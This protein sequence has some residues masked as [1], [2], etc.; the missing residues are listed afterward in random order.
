MIQSFLNSTGP[1]NSMPVKSLQG[2]IFSQRSLLVYTDIAK[3]SS[4]RFFCSSHLPLYLP[5]YP[6]HPSKCCY[7]I[8]SSSDV[9]A[10]SLQLLSGC[11]DWSGPCPARLGC[12]LVLLEWALSTISKTNVNRNRGHLFINHVLTMLFYSAFSTLLRC[13]LLFYFTEISVA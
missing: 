13:R 10:L 2:P 4:K 3:P 7:V 8:P 5:V 6:K 11:A 1:R 9:T 12:W